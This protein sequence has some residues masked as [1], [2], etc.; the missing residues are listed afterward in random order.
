[1]GGADWVA[2]ITQTQNTSIITAM[3]LHGCSIG[4]QARGLEHGSGDVIDPEKLSPFSGGPG[5]RLEFQAL[6]GARFWL[7][8]LR[9]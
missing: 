2:D 1:M 5:Y 3:L 9:Q 7:I 4:P 8:Q 6:P